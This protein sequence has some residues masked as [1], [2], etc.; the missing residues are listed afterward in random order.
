MRLPGTSGITPP[1]TQTDDLPI[2]GYS[3]T[4]PGQPGQSFIE[5]HGRPS[6]AM[7]VSSM[8]AVLDG[9]SLSVGAGVVPNALARQIG[10]VR[11]SDTL[12]TSQLWSVLH[13]DVANNGR[14]RIVYD[15][16]KDWFDRTT[17]PD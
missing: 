3:E 4:A 12:D 6:Y 8:Y 1:I 15:F 5:A 7:R 13:P 9:I 14:I 16:L 2:V 10:A 17:L 11:I